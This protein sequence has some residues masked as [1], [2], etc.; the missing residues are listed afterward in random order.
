M[1]PDLVRECQTYSRYLIGQPPSPYV[2]VKY[3]DYHRVFG[4]LEDG[5][6]DRALVGI[7][8]LHPLLAGMADSYAVRFCRGAAIR[9][10]LVVVLALSECG[11]PSS[12]YLDSAGAGGRLASLG[13]L[14]G[15]AAW[16]GVLLAAGAIVLGPVHLVALAARQA[17]R[18]RPR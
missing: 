5:W 3:G 10:K 14:A 11:W 4:A 2:L 6:F 8:R 9:K 17:E 1:P 15:R 12:E 16:H 7:S 18:G 13:R